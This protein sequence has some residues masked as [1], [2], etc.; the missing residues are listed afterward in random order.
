[1]NIKI[2]KGRNTWYTLHVVLIPVRLISD[3]LL[4]DRSK[5]TTSKKRLHGQRRSE[6]STGVFLCDQAC[7]H[8]ARFI[9][10]C[11]ASNN[12]AIEF[13][14]FVGN[15]CERVRVRPGMLTN[16]LL[17]CIYM[18]GRLFSKLFLWFFRVMKDSLLAIASILS[19]VSSL[20]AMIRASV[21]I[22]S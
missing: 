22:L 8:L 11:M 3:Q 12:C 16:C 2:T 18:Y 14:D 21:L 7:Y 4:R 19:A 5:M 6:Q 17:F 15:S 13:A 20:L 10:T 1:M 9:M